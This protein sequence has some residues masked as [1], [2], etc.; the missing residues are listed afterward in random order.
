METLRAGK[1]CS[2]I[3]SSISS[4]SS[5]PQPPSL[6]SYATNT[7]QYRHPTSKLDRKI[8]WRVSKDS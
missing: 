8:Y 3:S 6:Q 1:F 5:A 2:T 4:V 7:E